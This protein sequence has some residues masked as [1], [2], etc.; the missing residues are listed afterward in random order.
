MKKDSLIVSRRHAI[1]VS[2]LKSTA[3]RCVTEDTAF[4]IT[5]E[6]YCCKVLMVAMLVLAGGFFAGIPRCLS[7][8]II[9]HAFFL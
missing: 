1:V 8:Q 6:M 2:L 7:S 3:R 9:S 4:P 5:T